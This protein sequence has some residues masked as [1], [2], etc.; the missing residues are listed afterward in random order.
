MKVLRIRVRGPGVDST[1]AIGTK[2]GVPAVAIPG[3]PSVNLTGSEM[4]PRN[5][6]EPGNEFPT[7]NS[8]TDARPGVHAG[9]DSSARVDR[10]HKAQGFCAV[11]LRKAR[12]NAWL[13]QV[14]ELDVAAAIDS[15]HTRYARAAQAA[16][17]IIENG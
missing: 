2:L 15:S 12:G 17:A 4:N 10:L 6:Q 8:K 9:I 16:G 5:Q 1:R 3:N 13:V 14:Q 7:G 11:H